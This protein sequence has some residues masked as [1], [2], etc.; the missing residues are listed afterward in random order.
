MLAE[1]VQLANA[2]APPEER[3]A[4]R[5]ILVGNPSGL[6]SADWSVGVVAYS[7]NHGLLSDEQTAAVAA[8]CNAS[9]LA[10]T[11][12]A[13]Y[14]EENCTQAMAQL[15]GPGSNLGRIDP[16]NV[17]MP[18]EG[19]GPQ[20]DNRCATSR[21]VAVAALPAPA[22]DTGNGA[23]RAAQSAA[24]SHVRSAQSYIPCGNMSALDAYL[25]KPE[26]WRALHVSPH[27]ASVW[28]P[29]A[30]NLAW[31][32]DGIGLST[33]YSKL[34]AAQ[35]S[36]RVLVYSGDVDS[37]VP[38]TTTHKG[39]NEL[40][41]P[42]HSSYQPWFASGEENI[43]VGGYTQ[44]YDGGRLTFVTVRGAGHMVPTDRPRQ[45]AAF[46]ER[47]LAGEPI[48]TSSKPG[49]GR[50]NGRAATARRALT[51]A[52]PSSGVRVDVTHG[53]VKLRPGELV[54]PLPSS[55]YA[56]Q[57]EAES[58]Q[59]VVTADAAA[60]VSGLTVTHESLQ[61]LKVAVYRE[62]LIN[63]TQVSN[64]E[65]G[66]GLWPDALVPDVDVYAKEKRNAFPVHLRPGE[67]TV[68]WVDLFIPPGSAAGTHPLTVSVAS[69]AAGATGPAESAVVSSAALSLEVAPFS[70]P[71]TA[72]L[73]TAF[74]SLSSAGEGHGLSRSR[75]A[76]E[77]KGE[78]SKLIARY[79]D[80]M[81]M[82]R[83]S[84]DFLQADEQRLESNFSDWAEEWGS[85]F[86]G[87]TLP[88][89]PDGARVTTQS[90]PAPY[91]VETAPIKIK[92]ETKVAGF[93]CTS[94]PK[95]TQLQKKYWKT[96][97]ENLH[98]RGWEKPLFDCERLAFGLSSS[99][100]RRLCLT[101]S[102]VPDR[103]G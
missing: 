51:V 11:I 57:N 36:L 44:S 20:V 45:A 39:I 30:D 99:S 101:V 10:G 7:H 2:Q 103:H 22:S 54:P 15:Y 3:I 91:C 64:C 95:R 49:S 63:V 80:S 40:G 71:S 23:W 31:T 60:V 81:L 100:L 55:L 96:V 83:L 89:G 79:V 68:L 13:E 19:E 17:L 14:E 77:W 47:F 78:T 74:G 70:L 24:A 25:N 42:P 34:V 9:R 58:F 93:N 38:F 18:C 92:Y 85:F 72:T 37:C 35:P 21:A 67:R 4:L 97:Y 82:H 16:Y 33:L 5:G 43:N 102:L 59:V 88:F 32:H 41:L 84:G 76:P 87:R 90:L 86:S 69:S 53:L 61:S 28:R 46:F 27:A 6:E 29:C 52:G 94:T 56:A 1:Q 75:G 50:T 65:G 73:A 12:L 98:R 66:Y 48:A 8:A 26:V 62:A